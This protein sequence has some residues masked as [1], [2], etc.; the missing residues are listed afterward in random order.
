MTD[1]LRELLFHLLFVLGYRF[2][3]LLTMPHPPSQVQALP[4]SH[5]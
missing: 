2:Y 4:A 3:K 1:K 5:G